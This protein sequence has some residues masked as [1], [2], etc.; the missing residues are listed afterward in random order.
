MRVLVLGAGSHAAVVTDALLAMRAAGQDVEIVGLLDD[1]PERHGSQVLGVP[2]LGPIAVRNETPHDAV[3][4]AIGDNRTRARLHDEL[5]SH[6]E[7]CFTVRHP[8]AV[9]APDVQVGP[10]TVI[11]AGVVVNTGS[12]VGEGVILNTGC[13]VDHHNRIGA[14]AHIAPGV[15][16]AGKV[17]VDEGAM[18]GVGATAIP[19]IRIGAWAVVGAG[20]V[21][22]REV[23]ARVTVVGVPARI[24]SRSLGGD[25]S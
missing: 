13:T 8:R 17:T 2:V 18:V 6:D 16:L 22:V 4:V 1:N 7:H 19:G 20:A 14:F 15:H 12:S 5:R 24:R 9:L 3:V 21:V 11:F 25:E 10:G 23:P